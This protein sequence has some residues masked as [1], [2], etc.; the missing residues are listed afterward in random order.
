MVPE[1]ETENKNFQRN[2]LRTTLRASVV[3]VKV[4]KQFEFPSACSFAN[5]QISQSVF[6]LFAT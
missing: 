5:D 6:S 3:V 1:T 2:F 4:P